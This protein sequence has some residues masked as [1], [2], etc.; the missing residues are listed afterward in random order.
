MRP[1]INNVHIDTVLSDLSIDFLNESEGF[2]AGEVF[3]AIPVRHKSNEFRTYDRTDRLR[4]GVKEHAPGTETAGGG[5]KYGQGDYRCKT[6]G[7]HVDLD[8]ET[9][10]N[11]DDVLQLETEAAEF[12]AEKALINRELQFAG[13]YF[14][15]GVWSH[16]YTGNDSAESLGASTEGTIRESTT[17]KWSRHGKG[18]DTDSHPFTHMEDERLRQKLLTGRNPNTILMTRDVFN[19]LK[20]H[21]DYLDRLTGAENYE[22]TVLTQRQLAGIFEVERLLIADAVYSNT[23]ESINVKD[24]K[25][26][27]LQG[28]EFINGQGKCWLGYVNSR[29]SVRTVSAG[30]IFEW[31]GF[32]HNRANGMGSRRFRLEGISSERIELKMSYGMERVA[33]DCGTY[34]EQLV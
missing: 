24:H 6:Y 25:T 3:P 21:P 27:Q 9:V 18:D 11:A 19:V 14:K 4:D 29:P 28:N 31:T 17:P 34:W 16:E 32:R 22:S 13:T 23:A 10:D 7:Y 26:I 8:D 12:N 20:N 1:D 2:V 30:L 15:K 33:A 5:W